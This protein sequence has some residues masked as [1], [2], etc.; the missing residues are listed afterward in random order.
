[1]ADGVAF[2]VGVPVTTA[3]GVQFK[4]YS[5]PLTKLAFLPS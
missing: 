1:M 2:T 4:S 5:S 3:M